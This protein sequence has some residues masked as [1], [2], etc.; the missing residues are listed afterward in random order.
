MKYE[1]ACTNLFSSS[2]ESSVTERLLLAAPSTGRICTNCNKRVVRS[3]GEIYYHN[4]KQQHYDF[5]AKKK[6]LGILASVLYTGNGFRQAQNTT[7]D[8]EASQRIF[9]RASRS[10]YSLRSDDP[11]KK[12]KTRDGM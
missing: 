6:K 1:T 7:V 4:F 3:V 2:F 12:H 11:N 9:A 5:I 10:L 8:S